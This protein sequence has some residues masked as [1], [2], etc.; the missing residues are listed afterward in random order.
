MTLLRRTPVSFPN[1]NAL[2]AISKG[3][4]AVKQNPPVLNWRLTCIKRV[5]GSSWDYSLHALTAFNSTTD[6]H[7][8]K[9]TIEH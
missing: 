9:V 2:V 6:S 3:M 8:P 4:R 5:V 1:P 7:R